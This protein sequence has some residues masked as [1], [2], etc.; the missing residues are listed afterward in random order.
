MRY[1]LILLLTGCSTLLESGR[2][3][4]GW[5][6]LAI[7]EHRVSLIVAMTKCQQWAQ[8]W[9]F[10]TFACSRFDLIER[11]ADIWC[12]TEIL[13]A[14]E[15]RYMEGYEHPSGVQRNAVVAM[16]EAENERVLGMK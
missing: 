2:K 8:W 10:P 14:T 7:T 13:C 5:P 15:R 11:T 1:L 16:H 9:E 12:P 6:E 4:D 3:V